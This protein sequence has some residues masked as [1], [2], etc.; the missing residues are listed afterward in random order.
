[1][2]LAGSR[3][4]ESPVRNSNS[5]LLVMEPNTGTQRLPLTV[6]SS[7]LSIK[8][9]Y[10]VLVVKSPAVLSSARLSFIMHIRLTGVTGCPSSGRFS[11]F[12]GFSGLSG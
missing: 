6:F 9:K 11:G 1:M 4:M 12:S 10:S 5:V 8:G 3:A 2:E 7:R